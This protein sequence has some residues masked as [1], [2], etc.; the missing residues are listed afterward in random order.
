M[1]GWTGESLVPTQEINNNKSERID[2]D[3]F[4]GFLDEHSGVFG[5]FVD[6]DFHDN[7][8]A[9]KFLCVGGAVNAVRFDES[10]LTAGPPV[11]IEIGVGVFG[12][13]LWMQ[14]PAGIVEINAVGCFIILLLQR[15]EELV[16][17]VLLGPI[18][19]KPA[20]RRESDHNDNDDGNPNLAP[21]GFR[22][23]VEWSV[24]QGHRSRFR[25]TDFHA[26]GV[27]AW[28]RRS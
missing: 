17:G 3:C 10:P 20:E 11:A 5:P 1:L 2:G 9:A 14:A 22:V 15:V 8:A 21:P 26:S 16:H 18:A 6:Y 25:I 12:I 19:K 24:E 4:V 23:I 28:L 27:G 13:L 7:A